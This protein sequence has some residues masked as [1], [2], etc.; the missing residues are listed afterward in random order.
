MLVFDSAC[1]IFEFQFLLLFVRQNVGFN[2]K[3]YFD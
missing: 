2:L 3:L 1:C